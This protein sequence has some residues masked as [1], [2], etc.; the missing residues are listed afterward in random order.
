LF[1]MFADVLYGHLVNCVIMS[2][3]LLLVYAYCSKGLHVRA[4]YV[5]LYVAGYSLLSAVTVIMLWYKLWT[6]I[7]LTIIPA[8]FILHIIVVEASK[9]YDCLSYLQ[10]NAI[11]YCALFE[12]VRYLSVLGII[13]EEMDYTLSFVRFA[14]VDVLCIFISKSEIVTYINLH[15][16]K[17]WR[18][19]KTS[20]LVGRITRACATATT[21]SWPIWYIGFELGRLLVESDQNMDGFAT[22]IE[23]LFVMNYI[24]ELTSEIALYTYLKCIPS[25]KYQ[26][27]RLN[28]MLSLLSF[29]SLAAYCTIPG[30]FVCLRILIA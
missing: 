20:L 27:E 23:L 17:L 19:S 7:L 12:N 30:M 18:V 1:V 21:L 24:P 11:I 5:F 28:F 2:I 3:Y 8:D 9:T 25:G 22:K 14:A 15:T 10:V 4:I 26:H 29:S 16:L 13:G 6:A